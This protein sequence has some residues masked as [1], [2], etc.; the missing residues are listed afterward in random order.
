MSKHENPPSSGFQHPKR[1]CG[2]ILKGGKSTRIGFDK[3]TARY[4]GQ[5]FLDHS[6]ARLAPHCDRVAVSIGSTPLLENIPAALQVHDA[7][8]HEGPLAGILAGFHGLETDYLFV[9]AVDLPLLTD[10]SIR[11]LKSL[12]DFPSGAPAPLL[13]LAVEENGGRT[14]PLAGLWHQ[15]LAA[16]LADYLNKGKRSVMGFVDPF[17]VTYCGIPPNELTNVNTSED[18]SFI[19]L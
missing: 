12:I 16:P 17:P 10:A 14:Q 4:Q 2:L 1:V 5:S 7:P 6:M 11:R 19:S 15:S 3:S 13:V 9:L 8:P 18:L